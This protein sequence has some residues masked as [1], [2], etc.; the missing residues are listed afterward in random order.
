MIIIIYKLTIIAIIKLNNN[1]E[2]IVTIIN[3]S[4]F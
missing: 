3:L 1:F 4:N 2:I